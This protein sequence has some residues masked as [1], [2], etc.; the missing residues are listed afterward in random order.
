MEEWRAVKGYEG[1]YEVSNTGKV[2][3]LRTNRMLKP[4]VLPNKY[5]QVSLYKDKKREQPLVHRLVAMAFIENESNLPM[6]NHKDENK[7]NNHVF[8]LEWCDCRYNNNYGELSPVKAMQISRQK[9]VAQFSMDG[10]FIRKFDSSHEAARSTGCHQSSIS[11][12]CNGKRGYK[13]SGGYIWKF[14]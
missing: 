6:V 12:C 13:S 8:N 10:V 7:Q 4:L 2:R 1:L 11:H 3:S 14:V 9:S 5:L